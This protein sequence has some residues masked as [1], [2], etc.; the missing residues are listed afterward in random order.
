[1]LGFLMC[2]IRVRNLMFFR[3]IFLGVH[4]LLPLLAYLFVVVV[5]LVVHYSHIV[6]IMLLYFLFVFF[7]LHTLTAS[8]LNAFAGVSTGTFVF[9]LA[10][11]APHVP[12]SRKILG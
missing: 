11:W 8:V 5:I 1:M 3:L 4:S 2:K 7:F 12:V 6:E 9:R 10:L